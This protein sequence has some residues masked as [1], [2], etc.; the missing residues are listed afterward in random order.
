MNLLRGSRIFTFEPPPGIKANLMRTFSTVPAPRM[1]KVSGTTRQLLPV[2]GKTVLVPCTYTCVCTSIPF[3]AEGGV[4]YWLLSQLNFRGRLLRLSWLC[5]GYKRACYSY[6][7]SSLPQEPH[8]RARLYFLLAWF[9][10]IIQERLRYAPLGW[11]KKY[12]FN[13]SDLRM[14]CDT[15]DTWLDSV[16]QV[17]LCCVVENGAVCCACKR[18]GVVA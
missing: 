16:S 12:E 11:A 7:L 13:E 1:C 18:V 14:G 15:L 6:F 9:H 3:E 8:E 4:G 17:S 2:G 10:A 5:W